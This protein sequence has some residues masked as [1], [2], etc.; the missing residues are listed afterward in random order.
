[1]IWPFANVGIFAG[2]VLVYVVLN[3]ALRALAGRLLGLLVVGMA[4]RF[5]HARTPIRPHTIPFLHVVLCPEGVDGARRKLVL[6]RLIA[7][8]P[9]TIAVVF[10]GLGVNHHVFEGVRHRA[11]SPARGYPLEMLALASVL[12][13]VIG[14]RLLFVTAEMSDARIREFVQL[15]RR[16]TN[17]VTPGPIGYAARRDALLAALET[18]KQRRKRIH[19]LTAIAWIDALLQH[20]E[21]QDEADRYSAEAAASGDREAQVTRGLVLIRLGRVDEAE[22]LLASVPAR[23]LSR[24]ARGSLAAIRAL[25]ALHR[26][27]RALAQ[28]LYEAACAD[29]PDGALTREVGAALSPAATGA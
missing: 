4:R 29:D 9:V 8:V 11:F 16:I 2:A 10:V 17:P 22:Q 14:L 15:R 21:L 7:L 25:I 5:P 13:F 19:L 26:D 12:A 23:K 24:E 28:R 3:G 18:V 27:D 6:A 1:M 20:A